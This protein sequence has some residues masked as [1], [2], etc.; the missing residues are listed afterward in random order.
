MLALDPERYP[1]VLHDYH[2]PLPWAT[3]SHHVVPLAWTRAASAAESRTVPVCPTGHDA[4]HR[5]LQALV[6]GREPLR[7]V[8]RPT[9]ILL[10]EAMLWALTSGADR[11]SLVALHAELV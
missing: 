8:G 9:M 3:H 5:A 2:S 1:C 7:R 6:E 10:Q 4:L 11:D